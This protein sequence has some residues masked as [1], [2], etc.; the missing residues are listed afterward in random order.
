MP[1]RVRDLVKMRE[2][3]NR[4]KDKYPDRFILYQA[5]ISA[6]KKGLEFNLTLGD[7]Q[8]PSE[9][10]ILKIPLFRTRGKRTH[11]T[12]SLDRI[13]NSKGYIIG[14]VQVISWRANQ[15]KNNASLQELKSL[16]AYMEQ[17]Y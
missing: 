9:C 12:P 3:C 10:P 6:R 5:K 1:K 16:V 13:D 8:I 7:T 11:N 2:Y 15:L 17:N 14:N 4:Y